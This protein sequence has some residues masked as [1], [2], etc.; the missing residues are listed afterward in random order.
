MVNRLIDLQGNGLVDVVDDPDP[1]A[2]WTIGY[3]L[4]AATA[5]ATLATLDPCSE[6]SQVI[7]GPT[8][9]STSPKV[10]QITSFAAEVSARRNV[11]CAIGEELI[12]VTALLAAGGTTSACEYVLWHGQPGWD[13]NLAPSLQNVDVQTVSASASVQDTLA[14]VL[15][16][17]SALTAL[18]GHV[19]HL[20][21]KSALDLSA[22]GYAYG[23]DVS[24]ELRLRATGAPIVVS[25]YYPPTGIALT[26][27]I[28][29]VYGPIQAFQT[30]DVN[31]NRTNIAGN[32]L[33]V[34]EFDPSTSVRAV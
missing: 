32:R 25:P 19:I 13:N 8:D 16:A 18:Q 7:A 2:K 3:D 22:T 10:Y 33:A 30:Y 26:G 12:L 11:R 4:Q 20:G 1:L 34:I 15:N 27:P 6:Q 17:Y 29:V 23:T 5:A 14:S 21:L 28:K 31:I 9:P 24:G